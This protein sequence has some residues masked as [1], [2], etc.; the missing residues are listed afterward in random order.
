MTIIII[1]DSGK[2]NKNMAMHNDVFSEIGTF[3]A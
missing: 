1:I 3:Y 2:N